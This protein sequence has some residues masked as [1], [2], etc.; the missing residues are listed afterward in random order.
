MKTSIRS[1]PKHGKYYLMKR[2]F[3]FSRRIHFLRKRNYF[4]HGKQRNDKLL[5]NNKIACLLE[6]QCLIQGYSRSKAQDTCKT[7]D[8]GGRPCEWKWWNDGKK[9]Y[10]LNFVLNI[11]IIRILHRYFHTTRLRFYVFIRCV[12]EV[13]REREREKGDKKGV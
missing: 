11:F 12:Y 2:W 3:V 10:F 4:H 1:D 5:A 13:M 9:M 6:K 8:K 7:T